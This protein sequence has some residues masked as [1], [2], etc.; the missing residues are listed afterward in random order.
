MRTEL[1]LVRHGETDFNRKYIVQ[2]QGI[3]SELN[4]E[5]LQQASRLRDR[6]ASETIDAIYCSRL[7]RA[8]K[9]ASVVAQSHPQLKVEIE[10]GLEEMSFGDMEGRAMEGET[11]S[12]FEKLWEAWE[13][14]E[15][16]K[17]LPNGESVLD[18]E[19]RGV[20][21]VTR[22]AN[23][24]P[25][26]RVLIVTHGRFL[27]IVLSSVLPDMSLERMHEIEHANTGINQLDFEE[28]SF[29]ATL[30]NCTDHL[31]SVENRVYV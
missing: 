13:R 28:G 19:N 15:F 14:S 31:D 8:H 16:E 24:H 21:A 11:R 18:V 2:G 25:G 5:G 9:T 6:L 27:R 17:S 3:D 26:Q 4:E 12:F 30:L 23:R 10:P 22:I 1:L 20:A 29:R 7:K